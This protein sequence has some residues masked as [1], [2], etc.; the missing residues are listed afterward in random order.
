MQSPNNYPPFH[1]AAAY[2]RHQREGLGD[3]LLAAKSVEDVEYALSTLSVSESLKA[4]LRKLME[5]P[6]LLL[7]QAQEQL[8]ELF[9]ALGT[10]PILPYGKMWQPSRGVSWEL[11]PERTND[12]SQRRTLPFGAVYHAGGIQVLGYYGDPGD[13]LDTEEEGLSVEDV[14]VTYAL[15]GYGA[16]VRTAMVIGDRGASR[17]LTF[18]DSLTPGHKIL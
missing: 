18:V 14:I 13:A 12:S 6:P 8:S 16:A 10:M 9:V 3:L 7:E 1:A 5:Q 2:V 15:D 11:A 17:A 4:V